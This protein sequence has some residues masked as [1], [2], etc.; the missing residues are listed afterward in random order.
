MH[1]LPSTFF[2]AKMKTP[3]PFSLNSNHCTC[4]FHKYA[5]QRKKEERKE[6]K[7]ENKE[8][9][10][11]RR[12]C[13]R[14]SFEESRPVVLNRLFICVCLF[15]CEQVEGFFSLLSVWL[16]S[17]FCVVRLLIVSF[18]SWVDLRDVCSTFAKSPTNSELADSWAL[19]FLCDLLLLFQ[20]LAWARRLQR[21]TFSFFFFFFFFWNIPS[22]S[23]FFFAL[24][25]SI[26]RKKAWVDR[27]QVFFELGEGGG[28]KRESKQATKTWGNISAVFHFAPQKT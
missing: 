1:S 5:R 27:F 20:F 21:A 10:K 26:S 14:D 28:K 11:E 12:C 15:L 3:Y 13:S 9:R 23:L 6:I 2:R 4:W 19:F 25:F 17:C 18:L 8:R 7:K 16:I 22:S 24:P